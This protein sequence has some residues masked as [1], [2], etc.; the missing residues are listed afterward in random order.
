MPPSLLA[1]ALAI[2][3]WPGDHLLLSPPFAKGLIAT[4]WIV[5][6]GPTKE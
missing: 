1:A 5:T 6:F 3:P 4:G 2:T